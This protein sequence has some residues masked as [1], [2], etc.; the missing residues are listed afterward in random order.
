M[1]KLAMISMIC[2]VCLLLGG[3]G[4][5]VYLQTTYEPREPEPDVPR[6][7]EGEGE[8]ILL[9]DPAPLAEGL[10]LPF[11]QTLQ[12]EPDPPEW[13]DEEEL[14][15]Y[16][17]DPHTLLNDRANAILTAFGAPFGEIESATEILEPEEGRQVYKLSYGTVCLWV[18]GEGELVHFVDTSQI[19]DDYL[20]EE[21]DIRYDS[22]EALAD[23][24]AWV[25][26][27][28]GL[29]EYQRTGCEFDGFRTFSVRWEKR[30]TEELTNPH[31]YVTVSINA[32]NGRVS[33]FYRLSGMYHPNTVEPLVSEGWAR[34]FAK[35]VIQEQT[36]L[37]Y[38]Q[39]RP[40]LQLVRPNFRWEEG[41]PYAE[42]DIV[43]LA[44]SVEVLSLGSVNEPTRRPI[45]TVWIDARTGEV[46]GGERF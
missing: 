9:T 45:L 31:D 24:L 12:R 43:R 11:L 15:P 39:A 42:A 30:V 35:P 28:C 44:W 8:H 14:G 33:T 36:V 4:A 5:L 21:F 37:A 1:N 25:E 7:P 16:T 18:D 17:G 22:E 32:E 13:R 3:V 20:G 27:V 2:M 40:K 38:E 6:E 41:G 29:T 19:P 26:E 23:I 10:D 34:A 46:L